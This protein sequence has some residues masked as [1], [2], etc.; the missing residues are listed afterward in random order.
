MTKSLINN[1]KLS[2]L[3]SQVIH[4]QILLIIVLKRHAC[5][6]LNKVLNGSPADQHMLTCFSS[7]EKRPPPPYTHTV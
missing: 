4:P 3:T 2:Y 6:I 7:L 1:I 5:H